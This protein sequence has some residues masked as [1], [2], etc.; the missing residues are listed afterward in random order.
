MAKSK[1]KIGFVKEKGILSFTYITLLRDA[2]PLIRVGKY[3]ELKV[4]RVILIIPKKD[5]KDYTTEIQIL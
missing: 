3:P 1:K 2:I 5:M 4:W